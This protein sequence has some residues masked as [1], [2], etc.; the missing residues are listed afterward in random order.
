MIEEETIRLASQDGASVLEWVKKLREQGHFVELKTS[1]DMPPENSGLDCD[2][3]V[4]IIQ[5]QYQR[6]CWQKHAHRYAGIDATH[7]TTHYENMSLFTLLVRDKWGHGQFSFDQ[8][9]F[10]VTYTHF[11]LG[12][13][14]GWMI[15]SNGTEN[16]IRFFLQAI[17]SQNLAIFPEFFMS[18]K[19]HAQMN[20][21]RC[22][23]PK[24]T[25][26]LCW[27]HV[28]HA[29]QQ[30]FVTTHFPDLW[31]L[32]KG[33]IR[34]TDGEKFRECWVE[35][36]RIA[37]PSFRQYIETYWLNDV[38]LWSAVYRKDRNIFQ[39]CDTNMLVEA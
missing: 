4:L 11:S 24:S 6:E 30:H 17:H 26:L 14:A 3:F 27:W 23:Y 38:K 21:I 31:G 33:W 10:S 39:N 12:M 16:T 37:P 19:D 32:L 34:I 28:L 9:A 20:A 25:V 7:N 22:V 13:P 15:S 35:I 36:Q 2:S 5:T 18:D 8:F 29:W 1:S